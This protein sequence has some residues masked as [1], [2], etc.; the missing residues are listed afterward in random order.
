MANHTI[1]I[2]EL[3]DFTARVTLGSITSGTESKQ[4]SFGMPADGASPSPS[5]GRGL[6]RNRS[7][8]A[9]AKRWRRR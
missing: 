8:S 2:A 9:D 7:V 1:E 3:K 4:R 5:S 6:G